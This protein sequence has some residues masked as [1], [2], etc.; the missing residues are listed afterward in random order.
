MPEQFPDLSAN[1]PELAAMD[2]KELA[3]H[4]LTGFLPDFNRE[5]LA[6]CLKKAYTGKFTAGSIA[7]LVEKN[8][9]FFLELF[10]DPTLAFK[11]MALCLL[12][13]LINTARK[14][15]NI[16]ENILIL[17]CATSGDTGK[18]TLESFA[19]VDDIKIMVFYPS[20]GVSDI[21]KLQ[22]I[23]QAEQN[24][25]VAGIRGNF[26]S[27]QTGVKQIFHNAEKL[28]KAGYI[29]SSANSIN[30]GRLLPQIV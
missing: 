10:H 17:T 5:E 8:G 14:L 1:M 16:A 25:F 4:I 7:P 23:N 9:I 24:T 12:P 15:L 20:A 6:E 28:A 29:L 2:Y 22:I 13:H 26:D 30:I 19:D 3:C 18:A 27:A 21:P 11:D